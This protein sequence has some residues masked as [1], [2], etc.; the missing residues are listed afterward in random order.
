M[1]KLSILLFSFTFGLT[2]FSQTSRALII[3]IDTYKPENE[4]AVN[5]ER[6]SWPNLDGCVNDAS[7]MKDLVTAKYAFPAANIVTLY[8][9]KANRENIINQL[10]KLISESKKGDVVFIYY[11]GHGSQ[12]YNSLSKEADK[13][14]ETIVPS[15]AYKG[16]ADIRDKELAAYFNQLVDKGVVLTVIFDSC[17]S[18]SV[19]RGLLTDPP[20]VRFIEE[21]TQDAKDASEPIRP[22][23]RGAMIF[24]AAQDF[25]FAKEQRDENNI[26]HGAFTVALLKALQQQ[27]PDASVSSIYSS[28]TAIMK[29]YGKTQEPVLAANEARRAGTLF[30]LAKGAVKNKLTIA[31]SKIEA[32]GVEL[33]GGFAFGLAEGVKLASLNSTDTL[34]IIQMRGANKSLAKVLTGVPKN[35]KP[36]TLFEV[37]NWASSKAPALKVYVPANG[38]NEAQ[39]Q[40]F[41]K[42]VGTNK[43]L[44]LVGD[45][46]KEI[47][48][49]IYTYDGSQWYASDAKAGKK[50]VGA[51]P[52]NAAFKSSSS[53]ASSAF[54]NLPPSAQLVKAFE[55]KF[56]SFDNIVVVN[57][58]EE[59]QYTLVG[60]LLDG[61]KLGYA[62]VKSQVTVQ[63]T[64]ESLPARTDFVVYDGSEASATV[65]A[66]KLSEYAFRIA[67]I[68]D[69]LMLSAP[70]GGQNKFPF[71]LG[72]R[73]FTSQ[74][75]LTTD[76]VKVNDTLSIYFEAEKDYSEW[77]RKKRYIYVFNID[78]K[79]KMSLLYP[80]LESGNVENRMPA[81]NDDGNPVEK[82]HLADILITPPAGADNYFLLASEEAIS[83]LSAFEQEGVLSRGNDNTKGK[84]NP[85]ESLLFTGSKTRNKVITPVNWSIFKLVLRTAE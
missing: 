5:T 12:M 14:D 29:Y 6:M 48:N 24:S 51:M 75:P 3:G 11:A 57:R 38:V 66:E 77:N 52:T 73:H 71:K 45:I 15:D 33:Q 54:I 68:R 2:A 23:S 40:G 72:F 32:E 44:K 28:V 76:K 41:V 27:S 56:K 1:K 8:N 74:Q 17:H 37:I 31:S 10:K 39:L 22:E 81:T 84:G 80:S 61:N 82:T 46:T 21:N 58:P 26:P 20:K 53:S 67:K 49:T 18:G 35:I 85:L 64:T 55:N 42:N 60:S 19:G 4:A 30:G 34:E 50:A 79:G 36:G 43:S 59:S 16:A 78:S 7:S 13:K 47:P 9:D 69:W 83:N 63:D 70:S 65:V 62:L 25:E